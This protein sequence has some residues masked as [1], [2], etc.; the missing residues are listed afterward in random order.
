MQSAHSTCFS[1]GDNS[2]YY[3]VIF[4]QICD[5]VLY[6]EVGQYHH[7]LEDIEVGMKGKPRGNHW[8]QN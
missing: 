5:N 3:E 2:C 1:W 4:V 6:L 8:Y 7:E